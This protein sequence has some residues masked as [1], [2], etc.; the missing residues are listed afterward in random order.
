MAD[1]ADDSGLCWPSIA[2]LARK[3]RQSVSNTRYCLRRLE[4]DGVV[5]IHRAKNGRSPNTYRINVDTLQE[6][7][8]RTPRQNGKRG[9]RRE[10]NIGGRQS[11]VGSNSGG[12]TSKKT[13]QTPPNIGPNTSIK[14]EPSEETSVT[15]GAFLSSGTPS[16]PTV[17]RRPPFDASAMRIPAWLP[18]D[19]WNEF[20]QHRRE[21]RKPLTERAANA[22]IKKLAVFHSTG[23]NLRAVIEQTIASGWTGLFELKG[24]SKSVKPVASTDD[25]DEYELNMRKILRVKAEE[26]R[27]Q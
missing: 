7:A 2:T 6:V 25:P 11:L 14:V 18:L 1:W 9:G 4:N 24:L 16:T 21:L 8:T 15:S 20:V 22:N 17:K 10:S 26:G 13:L 19:A 3:A 27:S 5:T 12:Q 23:Q